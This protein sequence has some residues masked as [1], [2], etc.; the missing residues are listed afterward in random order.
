[1]SVTPIPIANRC[2]RP[3]LDQ[4]YSSAVAGQA[5]PYLIVF[6]VPLN[7][8]EFITIPNNMV[9]TLVL[10]KGCPFRDNHILARLAVADLSEPRSFDALT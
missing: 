4:R 5:C 2:E 6:D 3:A 9:I 10:P 7:A 1:M 8:S